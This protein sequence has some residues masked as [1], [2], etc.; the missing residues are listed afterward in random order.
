[1]V[2]FVGPDC[3]DPPACVKRFWIC[4]VSSLVC[5]SMLLGVMERLT[6]YWRTRAKFPLSMPKASDHASLPWEALS[7]EVCIGFQSAGYWKLT[8]CPLNVWPLPLAEADALVGTVAAAEGLELAPLDPLSLL[9]QAV[10]SAAAARTTQRDERLANRVD[11]LMA[12]VC[13]DN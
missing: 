3:M 7:P 12:R 11:L 5:W 2:S 10:K 13:S 6:L 9:L 8:P 1:M 4:V